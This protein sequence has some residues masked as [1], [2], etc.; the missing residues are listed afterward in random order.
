VP[1]CSKPI[2]QTFVLDC[3]NVKQ[4]KLPK[5]N[6]L[7]DKHL[8][9]FFERAQHRK[10]LLLNGVIDKQGRLLMEMRRNE[11]KNAGKGATQKFNSAFKPKRDSF[12]G[13]IKSGVALRA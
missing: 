9:G 1:S 5:Y 2:A 6:G 7:F 13:P 12:E 8:V 11:A 4:E 10:N 3:T